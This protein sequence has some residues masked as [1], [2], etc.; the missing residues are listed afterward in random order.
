MHMVILE[1]FHFYLFNFSYK[2]NMMV[3]RHS[4]VT[5]VFVNAAVMCVSVSFS[6]KE[7]IL[8]WPLTSAR[9][10]N[11]HV[12]RQK[13]VIS[14]TWCSKLAWLFLEPPA[15]SNQFFSE[16]PK[17]AQRKMQGF[18]IHVRLFTKI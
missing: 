10:N 7:K 18:C 4:H 1:S 15:I 3:L 5:A 16:P 2:S 9:F 17:A 8:N 14:S 12:W 11:K 6:K 13:D